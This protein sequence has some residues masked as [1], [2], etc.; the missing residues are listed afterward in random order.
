MLQ[1]DIEYSIHGTVTVV[2]AH[3]LESPGWVIRGMEYTT[4]AGNAVGIEQQ[5]IS[6]PQ[7]VLGCSGTD[8]AL[9]DTMG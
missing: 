3:E 1:D 4:S 9:V 8:G 7:Q 2:A 6:G 5:C